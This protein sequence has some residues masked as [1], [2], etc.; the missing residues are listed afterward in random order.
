MIDRIKDDRQVAKAGAASG[1]SL[2]VLRARYQLRQLGD[3]EVSAFIG[4]LA[5]T[6]PSPQLNRDDAIRTLALVRDDQ[7]PIGR[8]SV[9]CAKVSYSLC[10]QRDTGV[11]FNLHIIGAATET[12]SQHV[13]R[14]GSVSMKHGEGSP[15]ASVGYHLKLAF[16]P[17][18][19]IVP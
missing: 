9:Q 8:P 6:I 7:D 17:A 18:L 10:N 13:G 11:N 4:A 2:C 3:G 5:S 15:V 14:L 19:E 12:C 1:C 16:S